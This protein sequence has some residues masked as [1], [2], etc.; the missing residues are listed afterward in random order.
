MHPTALHLPD[1]PKYSAGSISLP[2]QRVATAAVGHSSSSEG[3]QV[4]FI[5]RF[6]RKRVLNREQKN[7]RLKQRR[8]GKLPSPQGERANPARG[9]AV[10][11]AT[12]LLP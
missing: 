10:E 7:K 12:N 5:S 8:A 2:L 1:T 3:S 6:C 11:K 9:R 4:V